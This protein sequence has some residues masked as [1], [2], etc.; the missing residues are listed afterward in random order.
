M[1]IGVRSSFV[2]NLS[3]MSLGMGN[4]RTFPKRCLTLS[5][6]SMLKM[7]VVVHLVPPSAVMV[8]PSLNVSSPMPLIVVVS[9]Q[10]LCDCMLDRSHLT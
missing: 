7:V 5:S 8:Q 4:D 6:F 10:N 3:V 1:G 9:S 2:M